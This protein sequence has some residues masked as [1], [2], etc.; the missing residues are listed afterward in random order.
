MRTRGVMR[1]NVA[2]VAS[3]ATSIPGYPYAPGRLIV[4][5]IVVMPGSP[6]MENGMQYGAFTARFSV[7]LIMG[8]AANQVT[9]SGLDDQIENALTGFLDSGYLIES[10]S[11]PYAL[12]ANGQQYLAATIIVTNQLRP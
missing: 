7:E 3:T 12:E 2:D 8:T 9:S 1:A 4:P 6:Y 10:V 5:S 11:A